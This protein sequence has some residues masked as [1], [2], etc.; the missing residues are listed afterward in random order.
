MEKFELQTEVRRHL[1][2]MAKQYRK[3]AESIEAI[4]EAVTVDIPKVE[5]LEFDFEE[6]KKPN[7]T[8]EEVRSALACK[9]RDGYTTEVR[10]L[11]TRFGASRLSEV[12]PKDFEVI[13]KEAEVI[14]HA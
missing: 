10:N 4:C 9:S 6:E 8:L 2:E 5:Q 12:K 3:L 7:I 13:L 1:L 11:I 14:G